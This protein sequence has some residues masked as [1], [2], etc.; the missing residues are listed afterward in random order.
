MKNFSRTKKIISLLLVSICLLVGIPL[1]TPS[2]AAA[3]LY[4]YDAN[5]SLSYAKKNVS[6]TKLACA[7]FVSKCVQAG[8]LNMKYES[9]TGGCI[10]SICKAAGIKFSNMTDLVAKGNG[11]GAVNTLYN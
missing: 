1:T 6:T 7:G 4:T 2:A 3:T 5:A 10:R 9:G 11:G 8:G